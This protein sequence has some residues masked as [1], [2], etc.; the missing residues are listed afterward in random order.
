[1]GALG[2]V[3]GAGGGL[4]GGGT[5]VTGGSA[6][7]FD[8]HAVMATTGSISGN[9]V[10]L[11]D[12]DL[13]GGSCPGRVDKDQFSPQPM[14]AAPAPAAAGSH[15]SSQVAACYAANRLQG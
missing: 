14:P 2:A 5:T 3:G 1:M 8:A 9:T 12:G 10:S 7:W 15:V 6:G 4:S 13:H 11:H